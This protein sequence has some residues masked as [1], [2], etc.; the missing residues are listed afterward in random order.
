MRFCF[1][2]HSNFFA[3]KVL[4]SRTFLYFSV[5]TCVLSAGSLNQQKTT[6]KICCSSS[7][8]SLLPSPPRRQSSA[9]VSAD[10]SVSSTNL[11][12]FSVTAHFRGLDNLRACQWWIQSICSVFVFPEEAEDPACI[13]IF[14]ISKWVDY[15]DKY[16]LGKTLMLFLSFIKSDWTSIIICMFNFYYLFIA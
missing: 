12:R 14:W 4:K 10:S 11:F 13:P 3:I 15:S 9:K 7:T 8:V 5:L 2:Q 16:G 1:L 6:W